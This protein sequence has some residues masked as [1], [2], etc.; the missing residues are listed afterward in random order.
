[1][2]ALGRIRAF[3]HEAEPTAFAV[4]EIRYDG[5]ESYNAA[6]YDLIER[7]FEIR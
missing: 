3:A 7:S 1:M 5:D 2:V 4:V 6:G